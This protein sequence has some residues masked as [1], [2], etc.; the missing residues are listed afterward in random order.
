[1]AP[2]R[3]PPSTRALRHVLRAGKAGREEAEE[4]SV[5]DPGSCVPRKDWPGQGVD[6]H[7]TQETTGRK[8]PV[9]H[10]VGAGV[11]E[12]KGDSRVPPT[13]ELAS[14][15]DSGLGRRRNGQRSKQ[16]WY[17]G[18]QPLLPQSQESGPPA[19]LPGPSPRGRAASCASPSR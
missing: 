18:P 4:V 6:T 14:V 16:I 11:S 13:P 7:M 8:G 2:W 15:D 12:F 19:A 17:M 1:M 3:C 5:G 9:W 10:V